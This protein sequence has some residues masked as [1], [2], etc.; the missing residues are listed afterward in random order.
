MRI[1]TCH[2]CTEGQ[3]EKCE[4]SHHCSP[5]QYGGSRCLCPCKGDPK[6]KEKF[7]KDMGLLLEQLFGDLGL[8]KKPVQPRDDEITG[9]D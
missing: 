2:W 7:L 3:H 5:G 6:W 8:Q 4:L 9:T 1:Y